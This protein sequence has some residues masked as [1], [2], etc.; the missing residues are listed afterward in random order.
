MELKELVVPKLIKTIVD[1][2][3]G[4]NDFVYNES[5]SVVFSA[6]EEAFALSR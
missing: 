5:Q 3:F 6:C 1:P 4:V 2:Q